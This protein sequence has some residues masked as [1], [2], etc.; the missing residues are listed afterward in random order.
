M[1]QDRDDECDAEPLVHRKSGEAWRK[2]QKEGN[3][4]RDVDVDRE[5]LARSGRRRGHRFPTKGS[6]SPT[7]SVPDRL[8]ESSNLRALVQIHLEIVVVRSENAAIS[9]AGTAIRR[10]ECLAQRI[11][12]VEVQRPD[13]I[14]LC[15]A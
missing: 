10:A 14:R 13:E 9:R 15:V 4:Q 2:Q 3:E 11:E 6:R 12:A 8:Q 5:S 7:A 1:N